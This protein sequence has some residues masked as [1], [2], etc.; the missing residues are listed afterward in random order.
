MEISDAMLPIITMDATFA[1]SWQEVNT[2]VTVRR[3]HEVHTSFEETKL[4]FHKL[5]DDQIKKFHSHIYSLDKAGGYAI[6]KS[7]NLI[8]SRIEGCYYNVMGFPVQMFYGELEKFIES[9][10]QNELV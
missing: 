8:V 6:E 10:M 5:T 3:G 4:L 1:G 9:S 2:G 7:A